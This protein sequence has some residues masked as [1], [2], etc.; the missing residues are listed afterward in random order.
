MELSTLSMKYQH[1]IDKLN[2]RLPVKFRPSEQTQIYSPLPGM[3][4]QEHVLE[5]DPTAWQSDILISLC[6]AALA[7]RINPLFSTYYFDESVSTESCQIF[8]QATSPI[9]DIWASDLA[10]ELEPEIM[11]QEIKQLVESIDFDEE[12]LDLEM[13]AAITTLL[14]Q[15]DR[16]SLNIQTEVTESLIDEYVDY[17]AKLPHNPSLSHLYEAAINVCEILGLPPPE[18]VLSDMD[19]PVWKIDIDIAEYLREQ[20]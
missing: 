19:I 16:Y 2:L 10:F 13:L 5:I 9:L 7:E 14:A 18:L 12:S 6:Q 11:S 20:S 15:V 8:I 3:D 4:E 17:V 1:W